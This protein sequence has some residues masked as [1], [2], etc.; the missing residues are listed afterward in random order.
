MVGVVLGCDA[1]FVFIL[2]LLLLL[3][4][5]RRRRRVG[6]IANCEWMPLACPVGSDDDA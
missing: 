1:L 4:Q 5:E 2:L 6:A 3:Q